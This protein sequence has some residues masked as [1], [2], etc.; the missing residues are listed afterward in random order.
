MIIPVGAQLATTE[1][2][3]HGAICDGILI[4][5]SS[6]PLSALRAI[7]GAGEV[8]WLLLAGGPAAR[9]R[10]VEQRAAL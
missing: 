7:A 1:L 4:D 6:L 9:A 8:A 10:R 2:N 5:A 3:N